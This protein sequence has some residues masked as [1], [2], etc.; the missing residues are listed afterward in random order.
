MRRSPDRSRILPL[1]KNFGT[2][3][4]RTTCSCPMFQTFFRR[5][6]YHNHNHRRARHPHAFMFWRGARAQEAMQFRIQSP[7]GPILEANV[8]TAEA[9]RRCAVRHHHAAAPHSRVCVQFWRSPLDSR[10]PHAPHFSSLELR[11]RFSVLLASLA[12]LQTTAAP[13]C[14]RI[15]LGVAC[16]AVSSSQQPLQLIR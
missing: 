15:R 13:L 6:N 2:K 3:K 1:I 8:P 12:T 14:R 7:R 10:L 9:A 5:S 4:K 11:F 16:A